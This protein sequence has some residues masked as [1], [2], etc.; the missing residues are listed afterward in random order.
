[1]FVGVADKCQA[2][3]LQ[4]FEHAK[5][6]LDLTRHTSALDVQKDSELHPHATLKNKNTFISVVT[7]FPSIAA[8]IIG[9]TV[10]EDYHTASGECLPMLDY[11]TYLTQI[12]SI[13]I[14]F[15]A[16][17][18]M[19]KIFSPEEQDLVGVEA[20]SRIELESEMMPG[21]LLERI[22]KVYN[23]VINKRK[24]EGINHN[25]GGCKGGV[26]GALPEWFI[27]REAAEDAMVNGI[28]GDTAPGAMD[29]EAPGTTQKGIEGSVPMV[30]KTTI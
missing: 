26:D 7:A 11:Q 12:V 28:Q 23:R 29:I 6:Q 19:W 18:A 16:T 9:F 8:A 30:E 17:L 1:V 20:F 27:E 13:V 14:A 2:I 4:A 10:T 24:A 3:E 5:A 25:L 22:I 15:I 21:F